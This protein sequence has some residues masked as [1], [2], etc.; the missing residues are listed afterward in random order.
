MPPSFYYIPSEGNKLKNIIIFK[1]MPQNKIEK[2]V[3]LHWTKDLYLEIN[4]SQIEIF[5]SNVGY[6]QIF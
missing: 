3:N 4:Y 2:K 5:F 6:I 1:I